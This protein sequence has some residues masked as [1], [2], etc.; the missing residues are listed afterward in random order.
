MHVVQVL[1]VLVVEGEPG[2]LKLADA[3]PIAGGKPSP[4]GG[5]DAHAQLVFY[6]D[7]YTIVH[8]PSLVREELFRLVA[9]QAGEG[10]CGLAVPEGYDES[11]LQ[12]HVELDRLSLRVEGGKSLYTKD[13]TADMLARS[14]VPTSH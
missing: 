14:T 11:S 3:G 8:S 1:T 2:A 13:D 5:A 4:D 12:G 10:A 7:A 9:S 6:G